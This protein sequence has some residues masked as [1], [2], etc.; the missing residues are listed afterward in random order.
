MNIN[1]NYQ[2]QRTK[3]ETNKRKKEI[4]IKLLKKLINSKLR[5]HMDTIKMNSIA[6]FMHRQ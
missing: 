2:K 6:F 5:G 1:K 3:E 4:A